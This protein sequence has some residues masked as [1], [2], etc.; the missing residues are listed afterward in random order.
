MQEEVNQKVVS[1]CIRTGRLTG[2]VLAKAMKMFLENQKRTAGQP[3]HGK[4]SFK[5]LMEQ[6]AGAASIEVDAGNIRDFDRV[7]RRYHVDYA[8]RRDKTGNPPKYF[9]FFKA[10]DQ[11]SMA[12]AFREFV[13][14]NDKRRGRPSFRNTLKK[15]VEMSRNPAKH[16][17]REKTKQ[18]D[19]GQSL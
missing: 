12:M 17:E 8:V 10:R 3:A 5:R 6:N 14:K 11:D 4:Q 15:F 7:A 2:N 1:L 13:M 19:R 9:V 16:R 18:K